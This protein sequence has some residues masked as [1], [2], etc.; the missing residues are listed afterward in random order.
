M[1]G[2]GPPPKD[3]AQRRRRNKEQRH[4]LPP[5]PVEPAPLPFPDA[6]CSDPRVRSWWQAIVDSPMAARYEQTDWVRVDELVVLV[7]EYWRAVDEGDV[8]TMLKLAQERR[9]QESLLGV[10][11][12]D[13]ARLRWDVERPKVEAESP[14]NDRRRRLRVVDPNVAG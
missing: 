12:V 10:T 7:A 5:T 2:K 11:A 4:A 8:P 13:R 1:A 9:L 6:M 3:P 14:V